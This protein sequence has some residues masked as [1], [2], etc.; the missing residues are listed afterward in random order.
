MEKI[1][2]QSRKRDIDFSE[3]K[4]KLE[5]TALVAEESAS[6][7][8]AVPELDPID[9]L[10]Y[11]LYQFA[12]DYDPYEYR[13]QVDNRE[14]AEKDLAFSLR[15]GK[16]QGVRE[17]LQRVLDEDEPGE[18][19]EKATELIR[20]LDKLIP[21]QRKTAE[22]IMMYEDAYQI[23][24]K[25]QDM[26][27]AL[28]DAVFEFY[29]VQE[30]PI[31]SNSE[32]PVFVIAHDIVCYNDIDIS[33]VLNSYGYKSIK[34]VYEMY[35]DSWQQIMAECAFELD[36]GRY[37]NTSG[38]SM[39]WEESTKVIRYES[40]YGRQEEPDKK[41]LLIKKLVREII[42]YCMEYGI[43]LT[44]Y[45]EGDPAEKLDP[46]LEASAVIS[47]NLAQGNMGAF[48]AVLKENSEDP[49]NASFLKEDSKRL[50]KMLSSKEEYFKCR[51]SS[52]WKGV[53]RRP[54]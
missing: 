44:D 22:W 36:A 26:S 32:I 12:F 40:G 39:T 33:L 24:R 9:Q 54:K 38:L 5:Q 8:P 19:T 35:G 51:L 42:D 17:W 1:T 37:Y 10:A 34:E 6:G 20:R 46:I 4:K 2:D 27:E 3:Q 48:L 49:E 14:T 50:L 28:G 53:Q 29:Q 18:G 30:A 25:L 13:D 52:T 43:E 11:D 45:W 16:K 23:C 7:E 15:N 31:E 41:W 21:E 47:S